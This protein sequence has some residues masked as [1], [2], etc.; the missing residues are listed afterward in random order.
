M[1]TNREDVGKRYLELLVPVPDTADRARTVSEPFR[2]YYL[3]LAKA[4]SQFADYLAQNRMHHFFVTGAEPTDPLEL[5]E[6]AEAEDAIEGA[7]QV[8]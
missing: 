6:S 1:Q 7:E 5:V 8:R 3:S 2:A 4:R